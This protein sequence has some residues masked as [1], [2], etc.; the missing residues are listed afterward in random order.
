M[1]T[2]SNA[3]VHREQRYDIRETSLEYDQN[4]ILTHASLK[5]TLKQPSNN[6]R[7]SHNWKISAAG[8]GVTGS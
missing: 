6:F 4:W 2:D 7:S 5:E 8:D 3:A 1:P